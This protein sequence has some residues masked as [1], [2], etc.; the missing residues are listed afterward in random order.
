MD[1][2]AERAPGPVEPPGYEDEHAPEREE[3]PNKPGGDAGPAFATGSISDTMIAA[4][5]APESSGSQKEPKNPVPILEWDVLKGILIVIAIIAIAALSL[6]YAMSHNLLRGVTHTTT[7]T[8]STSTTALTTIVPMK[9]IT[10]HTGNASY[11]GNSTI[12][13]S[14]AVSPVPSSSGSAVLV[15][16]T[17]PNGA[18]VEAI[19]VP[20]SASGHFETAF[21][22]GVTSAWINGTYTITSNYYGL[23]G[24]TTFGWASAQPTGTEGILISTLCNVYTSVH[25]TI[26]LLCIM[27]MLFGAGVYAF[28]HI[29]P[30][31]H[32]GQFQSYGMGLII[33]AIIGIILAVLAP[34]ILRVIA[35]NALPIA[36]CAANQF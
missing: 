30:G 35:G 19:E 29:M 8:T 3:S 7:L 6:F 2:A 31:A 20:L 23:S 21:V 28:G 9:N 12:Q 25:N 24:R 16:V 36:S 15:S 13:V 34:Y 33:G 14:G 5:L 18:Q 10:V 4:K 26:F 17:N 1:Y 27:L 11:S 32:K 22:G